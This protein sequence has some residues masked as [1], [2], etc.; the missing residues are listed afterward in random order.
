MKGALTMQK[1]IS[2]GAA[3]VLIL[4]F[5]K[6]KKFNEIIITVK[7]LDEDKKKILTDFANTNGIKITQFICEERSIEE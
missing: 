1:K 4:V 3:L 7:D 6:K 5:Y 2:W